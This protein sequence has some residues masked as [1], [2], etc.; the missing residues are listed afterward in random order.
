MNEMAAAI[1]GRSL[2]FT[3]RSGDIAFLSAARTVQRC[4]LYLW[5][6]APNG[7]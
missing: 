4:T 6:D 2:T 5:G 7:S 1:F 3:F